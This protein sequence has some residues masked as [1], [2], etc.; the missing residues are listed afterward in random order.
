[1]VLFL[2]F[3]KKK[4]KKIGGEATKF[5]FFF[6]IFLAFQILHVFLPNILAHCA[7]IEYAYI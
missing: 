1:M 7:L 6:F 5:F 4:K 3:F 2:I